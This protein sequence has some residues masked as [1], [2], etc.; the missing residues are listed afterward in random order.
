MPPMGAM[1]IT[2]SAKELIQDIKKLSL[3]PILFHVITKVSAPPIMITMLEMIHIFL[4]IL[5]IGLSVLDG[6]HV[7]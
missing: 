3:N 7:V 5:G 6:K 1:K 2:Q 4:R